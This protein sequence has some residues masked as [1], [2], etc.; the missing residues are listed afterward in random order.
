MP[1][2]GRDRSPGTRRRAPPP[3][4]APH[5]LSPASQVDA[6]F[7]LGKVP[8][9]PPGSGFFLDID[10]TLLDIVERPQLV[11]IDDGLVGL[12]SEL[13]DVAGGALALISGRSIAEIDRLF[14][15]GDFC[16][17]GQHGAERRGIDG[18]THRHQVPL[19]GLRRAQEALRGMVAR[20]PELV[21]E[22][23]GV[24]LAVHYRSAPDLGAPVHELVRRLAGELGDDFEVQAGKMVIEIK[25]S[26]KDKGTAIA[27]FLEEAPFRGRFAVFIGDDL[28]DEFGFELI[29]RVGGCSVKVGEGGSAAQWRLRD[30]SAVRGWLARF[31]RQRPEKP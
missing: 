30:A 20:H 1:T 28:S 29:N 9:L 22:D 25:P 12:L 11:Q 27:E 13:R 15:S 19:A 24:N 26:G 8:R 4:P 3:R 6:G 2:S 10:G 7:H 16:V 18:R 23:K 21:L 14:G 31:T 5:E 17:A